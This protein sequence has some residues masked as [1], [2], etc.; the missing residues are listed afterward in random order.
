[1]YWETGRRVKK[2]TVREEAHRGDLLVAPCPGGEKKKGKEF[3][4]AGSEE[5]WHDYSPN[6]L[7]ASPSKIPS[8]SLE[9]LKIPN[10]SLL[11]SYSLTYK[12]DKF[13][14]ACSGRAPI[15]ISN[16]GMAEVSDRLTE[17]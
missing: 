6:F 2:R 10:R 15:T 4:L 8:Y 17:L 9:S 1:M 3:I 11:S 5:E 13:A 16:S 7:T 12:T 14:E